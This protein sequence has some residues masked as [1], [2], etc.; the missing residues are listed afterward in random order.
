ML[1]E[2]EQLPPSRQHRPLNRHVVSHEP[3]LL[4]DADVETEEFF[5]VAVGDNIRVNA[6]SPILHERWEDALDFR[7]GEVY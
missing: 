7:F 4:H 2:H 5:I 6:S 1:I 3:N